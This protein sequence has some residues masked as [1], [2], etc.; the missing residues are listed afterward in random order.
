MA[1]LCQPSPV[2]VVPTR[3]MGLQAA[4]SPERRALDGPAALGGLGVGPAPCRVGRTWRTAGWVARIAELAGP[5]LLSPRAG[6]GPASMPPA[7]PCCR[8]GSERGQVRVP[9][10]R[11]GVGAPSGAGVDGSRAAQALGSFR[12]SAG[13]LRAGPSW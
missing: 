2:L 7:R 10:G 12:W 4:P 11:C 13:S 9:A 5:V 6:T 3:P 8:T 1:W